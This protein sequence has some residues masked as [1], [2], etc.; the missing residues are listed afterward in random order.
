MKR[1]TRQQ[2]TNLESNHQRRLELSRE[3]VRVLDANE[4]SRA[5][6]GSI[7]TS[8]SWTTESQTSHR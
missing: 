8:T 5:V 6:G 1:K 7:C 2:I 4:L 3:T